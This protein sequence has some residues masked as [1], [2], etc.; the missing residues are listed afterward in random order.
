MNQIQ[1]KYTKTNEKPR[2]QSA[3]KSDLADLNRKFPKMADLVN[4]LGS[5]WF[6]NPKKSK[7]IEQSLISSISRRIGEKSPKSG[8]KDLAQLF[9][10]KKRF[11]RALK[12]LNLVKKEALL[13]AVDDLT[14]TYPDVYKNA[15]ELRRVFKNADIATLQGGLKKF[16]KNAL[17]LAERLLNHQRSMLLKNPAINFDK[18]LLIKRKAKY[19]GLAANFQGNSHLRQLGNEDEIVTLQFKESNATLKTLYKPERSE[20][21]TDIEL[22][23]NAEKMMFSKPS[24]AQT[25]QVYEMT[26]K[27]KKTIQ[28][29]QEKGYGVHNYDSCYLPDGNIIYT[30][31]APQNGVPCVNG[32]SHVANNFLLNRT[33]GHIRQIC[34]DQEH[35][36]NP[37]VMNDGKVLYQ[38]WEYTD[39]V[40]SNSRILFT[41]NPDGT[42]QMAYYGSN[43]YWPTAFFYARPIPDHPSKVVGIVGGHHG[44]KRMG[45]MVILDSSKGTHEADGVVQR[46]TDYGKKVE[47]V[48]A[49]KLV[50]NSWP[51]FLH[52]YPI[53]D[54]YFIVASQPAPDRKWGL[55]L[56]DVWDNMLLLKEMENYVL[57]EPIP[58]K[59]RKRPPIIPSR[60]NLNDRMATVYIQNIYFGPGLKDIPVGTVKKLRVFSYTF[61]NHGQGGFYGIIGMDGP[62]DIR[63]L[64][65]EVPVYKDGSALFKVPANTPIAIQPLDSEGKALQIMRSWFTA[66]PGEVVA[67]IGCHENRHD[68]PPLKRVT[69]SSKKPAE[70]TRWDGKRTH[71]YDYTYEVQPV[72]DKY[73]VGC[74]DGSKNLD[75]RGDKMIKDYHVK[76]SGNGIFTGTAGK[77]SVSY[78][79]LFPHV[80]GSGIESPMKLLTPME[81]HA[82]A[83]DLIQM[84][85]KGHHNV[86]LDKI[87]KHKLI[88]WIDL[89][90]PY[91]G[92]RATMHDDNYAQKEQIRAEMRKKYSGIEENHEVMPPKPKE[93]EFIKPAPITL[94]ANTASIEDSPMPN[95]VASR[96]TGE[97][98]IKTLD[99][100][101]KILIKLRKIPAGSFVMG[102]KTG[103]I[104]A[105]P[106]TVVKIEKSFWMAESEITNAQMRAL[107]PKHHSPREDRLGYQF[108]VLCYDVDRPNQPA[109]R[110]S[111][112]QAM[113][114][115][116]T[117]AQKTGL[118]IKLP[119]EAQWE[120]AARAG[121][122]KPFYYGDTNT[123][124]GRFANLSDET[125]KQFAINPYT[126][127]KNPKFYKTPSKYD[128]YVPSDRRFNDGALVSVEVKKY[129]PNAWGLYD[130]HGN[131]AEWTRSLFEPYPYAE[132]DGRNNLISAE[133]RVVRGGSWRDR[134]KN[135]TAAF[136]RRYHPY[137][138]V[139]NVGFRIIIEE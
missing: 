27:D 127:E 37:V 57:F 136:R 75:L 19:L 46:I 22:D 44:A 102:N 107:F 94:P 76:H 72:L 119:T 38:R 101:N 55:Y 39:L 29:T 58:L 36:W 99:L 56:V 73:C 114:F 12:E 121:S 52:P 85:E 135:A 118:S 95:T 35:N 7:K 32:S 125:T 53:D 26:L 62:W 48:V 84:L 124:F 66:M 77:F 139:F 51:K 17:E 40:H 89:N 69:A 1:H 6:L 61:A 15:E 60:V 112:N 47:P 130:M 128:A 129:Q 8:L 43:S 123:D 117:A 68:T 98:E 103:D 74:H 126:T 49:D 83:T 42:N 100:G 106:T 82:D 21:I 120:Y 138:R 79:N 50:D 67:C 113:E 45:E 71:G 86:K 2:A 14:K 92:T 93:R 16:D 80:R 111:W 10:S 105:M 81:F 41:M 115:C 78:A 24:K 87:A 91:H 132:C 137:H 108:G 96:K 90:T 13:R 116:K 70:I 34:F 88:T 5:N 131:A 59:A 104:T 33:T 28:L 20:L 63:R 134:P 109:V 54:K 4:D 133:K 18:L 64:L 11:E 31:T 9:L 110:V 3:V 65:G 30:S 97:T 25:W 23:F 122:D